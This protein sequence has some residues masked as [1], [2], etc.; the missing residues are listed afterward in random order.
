[1]GTL[2]NSPEYYGETIKHMEGWAVLQEGGDVA[3]LN[4][5]V[6]RAG[7]SNEALF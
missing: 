1:M 6:V 7:F 3:L 2:S 5:V 4:R